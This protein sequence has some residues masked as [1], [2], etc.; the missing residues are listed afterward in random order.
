MFFLAQRAIGRLG[1]NKRTRVGAGSERGA[2]AQG[3]M[4][5]GKREKEKS[6]RASSPSHDPLRPYSLVKCWFS[7]DVTKFQT[8][9]LLILLIFYFH[10]V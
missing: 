10:D 2:R 3:A 5:R 4:G 6:L 1:V 7:H 8:T 9:K